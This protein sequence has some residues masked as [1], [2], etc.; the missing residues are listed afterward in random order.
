MK[1][2]LALVLLERGP[3]NAFVLDFEDFKNVKTGEEVFVIGNS[4]DD[5]SCITRG[6]VSD[7]LRGIARDES[8]KYLM[9]DCAINP[10]NSGGPIFNRKGNVIG[11]MVASRLKDG[12]DAKGMNYAIPADVTQ[13]FIGFTVKQISGGE[14]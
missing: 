1:V 8:K 9:T 7:R 5:G 3:Q 11:V 4:L 12:A 6:I 13:A 2:W 10:G 14:R